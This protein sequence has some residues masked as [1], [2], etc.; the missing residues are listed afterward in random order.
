MEDKQ[1]ISEFEKIKPSEFYLT[2]KGK[3]RRIRFGNRAL[4]E[5]EEKY[6]TVSI[7]SLDKDLME[8]PMRNIP[9]LFSICLSDEDREDIGD[10]YKD[11]LSAFDDSNLSVTDVMKVVG[12]AMLDSV[13]KISGV[14]SKKKTAK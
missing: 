11:I 3:K 5:V 7:D 6:G 12:A 2:V 9:W 14:D 4:A 10:S 13:G 8:R 1:E